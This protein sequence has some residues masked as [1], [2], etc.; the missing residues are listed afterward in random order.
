LGSLPGPRRQAR[1]PDHQAR[2]TPASPTRPRRQGPRPRPIRLPTRPTTKATTRSRRRLCRQ[3]RGS[4]TRSSARAAHRH[5]P[6][7]RRRHG[8]AGGSAAKLETARPARRQ[9]PPAD[10]A[11]GGGGGLG[12]FGRLFMPLFGEFR[13][14][15]RIRPDLGILQKHPHFT[16]TAPK[17]MPGMP[18]APIWS[19]HPSRPILHRIL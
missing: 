11:R 14:I 3:A 1:P 2:P 7:P 4:K 5:G 18:R 15:D 9:D 17:A 10:T 6:P 8:L 16:E 13:K 19:F 12:S